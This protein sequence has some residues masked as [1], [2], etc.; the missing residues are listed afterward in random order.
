MRIIVVGIPIVISLVVVMSVIIGS[1]IAINF[2]T[3]AFA[4]VSERAIFCKTLRRYGSTD[5]RD[6]CYWTS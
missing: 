5:S 2:P 4:T 3:F 6:E 1:N